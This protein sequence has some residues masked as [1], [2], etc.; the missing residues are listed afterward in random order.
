MVITAIVTADSYSRSYEHARNPGHQSLDTSQCLQQEILSQKSCGRRALDWASDNRYLIVSGSWAASMAGALGFVCRNPYL[1]GSQ[2]LVQA[3]MYAQGLT[4]GVVV[5]SLAF[6][7][8]NAKDGR[9]QWETVRFVDP[10]DPEQ[11]NILKKKI[12][13]ERY[14]GE[15][16]WMDMVASEENRMRRQKDKGEEEKDKSVEGG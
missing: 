9:S 3:R 1:T 13:H 8:S 14:A 6:E 11:K 7:T 16:R 2:K 12:H 15:D 10:K 5:L 4:L